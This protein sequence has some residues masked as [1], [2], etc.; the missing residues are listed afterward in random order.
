MHNEKDLQIIADPSFEAGSR[1]RFYGEWRVAFSAYDTVLPFI[2]K[3]CP[4]FFYSVNGVSL[5]LE[6]AFFKTGRKYD[7]VTGPIGLQE[8]RTP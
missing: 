3:Q 7:A 6:P 1:L 5:T 8:Q 2:L 4:L